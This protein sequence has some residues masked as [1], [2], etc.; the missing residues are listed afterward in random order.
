GPRP[1]DAAA[2]EWQHLS[3]ALNHYR[4]ARITQRL[5]AVQR[6]HA[7]SPLAHGPTAARPPY[8][9]HPPPGRQPPQRP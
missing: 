2:T 9:P 5:A 4:H 6:P 3:E 7:H 1:S 8:T